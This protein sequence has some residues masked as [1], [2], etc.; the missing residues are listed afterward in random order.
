MQH[1]LVRLI[2]ERRKILDNNYIIVAILINLLKTFYCIPH[3]LVIPKLAA[4]E[5]DKTMLCY[6]YSYLKSREK[7][8]RCKQY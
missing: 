4:Y 7:C 8:V 5:F 6:I 2:E 1:V 3:D